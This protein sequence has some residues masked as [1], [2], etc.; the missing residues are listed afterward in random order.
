MNTFFNNNQGNSNQNCNIAGVAKYA[1]GDY[2]ASWATTA[3]ITAALASLF[4]ATPV[5]GDIAVLWNTN[6]TPSGRLYVYAASA[7]KTVDLT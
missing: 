3:A 7:W 4:P 2:G 5:N 6:G 1:S